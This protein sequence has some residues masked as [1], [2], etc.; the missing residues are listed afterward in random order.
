MTLT[1]GF[2]LAAR[3]RDDAGESGV[4]AVHEWSERKG[5]G[6]GCVRVRGPSGERPPGPGAGK[7]WAAGLGHGEREKEGTGWAGCWVLGWVLFSSSNLFLKQTLK[8]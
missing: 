7:S 6:V 1:C 3:G 5:E 4:R 8:F 2:G